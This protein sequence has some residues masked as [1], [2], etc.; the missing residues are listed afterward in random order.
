ME[1]TAEKKSAEFIETW[2][3]LQK[4]FMDNWTKSQKE[5]MENWLEAAKK[6]QESFLSL[7]PKQTGMPGKD[8][9]NMYN[10][11]FNTMVNS[12]KTFTDEAMK[13]QE[14]WKTAVEKQMSMGK[15]LF[16]GFPDFPGQSAGKA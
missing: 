5:F 4:D 9:V 16:K 15:D 6:M 10:T 11:W 14:T 1:K 13:V 2:A 7:E 8:M 12:S 3:K